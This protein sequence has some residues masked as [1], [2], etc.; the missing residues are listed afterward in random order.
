MNPRSFPSIAAL[1]DHAETLL[2]EIDTVSLDIFD[3]IF[4]R[5]VPDPDMVKLPV[6]RYIADEAKELGI[7]IPFR[8][9]MQSRNRIEQAH[10]QRNGQAHPDFEA[11]Y[12]HFMPEMLAEIFGDHIPDDLFRRVGDFEMFMEDSMLVLREGFERWIRSLHE[13]GKHIFLISDI[14]LP[15]H[16]LKRLVAAKGIGD[17]IEDVVSSADS[18]RAKAS[19]AAWPLV[20]ERYGLDRNRWLH[21]GDNPISDGTRPAEFGL[22]ALIIRDPGEHH[23]KSLATRYNFYASKRQFWKGRNLYQW[24]LPLE[25]ENVKRDP[26]YVDGYN[27]LGY[28]LS[29]FIH[30]LIERCKDRNIEQVYF[31]SREG[32]TF[33]RVWEQM[34]PYY[35]PHGDAPKADYLYV[36]RMALAGASCGNHGMT[37]VSATVARFPAGN[38]D[39]RD[40]CRIFSLD[41]DPLRPFLDEVGLREDDPIGLNCD[42]RTPEIQQKFDDLLDNPG[43]QQEIRRQ[44]NPANQALEKHL[45]SIGFFDHDKVAFV[46]IGWLGTIQHYLSDAMD[47][48]SDMPRINGFLLGAIR[49]LPYRDTW[50]NNME[51]L[52]HDAERI[53]F[54]STL[55]NYI[56]KLL[57]ETC[58]A[59]HPTVM[60][61]DPET[62]EPVF[63]HTDDAVG[64]DEKRQDKY[65]QPLR[66]GIFDAARRYAAADQIYYYSSHETQIWLNHLL[67][68]RV[69][70]PKTR[71]VM[72]LRHQVH[73]DD[74]FG[75]HQPSK[76]ALKADQTLWDRSANNLRFNPF[77]RTATFLKHV[78][79]LLRQ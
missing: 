76:R 51:G 25:G 3:T 5:R 75:Q 39:F 15:A 32:W 57:E 35:Y 48:R 31:C 40:V 56:K 19:G 50:E 29:V 34:A 67:R 7:E 42:D 77:L 6:A 41:I 14:Y 55:I 43:F 62:G 45:D 24:M 38:R 17:C 36:S 58:R 1:V 28:L 26:L 12:D 20:A 11:N 16:Y 60:G 73:Q 65:Y 4:I 46:D 23:R 74:F 66:E 21:V 64:Q 27:F 70:F 71:E 54:S 9:V 72:R 59:P 52:I 68:T 22:Q 44:T 2:P 61:Y 33:M 47:H 69:A 37:R 8:Q 49:L 10:R 53:N 18:I 63:R 30:R 78:K 13:R 79:G